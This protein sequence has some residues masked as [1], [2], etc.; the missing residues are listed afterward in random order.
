MF[1]EDEAD[2]LLR[3][4]AEGADVDAL[5]ARRVAG[6]PLEQV[7]GWAELCGVRIQVEPGVFVPRHRTELLVR[8]AVEL[9][10][11]G[12]VVVDLCCGS[13]AIGAALL[14][15]VDDVE[16]HAADV[17]PVAVRCARRNLPASERVHEGDLFAPLPAAL[18]GRVDLLLVNAPYVPTDEL[19]LL[20]REAREHEPALALDGGAGGVEVHR[21]VALDAHRWLSRAGHLLVETSR[22][23]LPHTSAAFTTGGLDVRVATD[24]DLEAT[25][26]VG[27]QGRG[28]A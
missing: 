24:D 17:D 2:L 26:V 3:A 15:A 11:P 27:R 10:R 22:H 12:M 18:R 6:E 20:P 28:D 1:A 23:Q 21:R 7:V 9:A 16:L 4:A 25:V 8:A 13:G 19:D 14:D 5:V